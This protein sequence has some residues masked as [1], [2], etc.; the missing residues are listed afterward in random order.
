MG[1]GLADSVGWFRIFGGE[2]GLKRKG[3][4]SL[5]LFF[6]FGKIYLLKFFFLGPRGA[7]A[8]LGPHLGPSLYMHDCVG[9]PHFC[10]FIQNDP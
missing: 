3:G 6:F 5:L 7:R 4:L 8:L 9:I 10:N 1:F 2:P